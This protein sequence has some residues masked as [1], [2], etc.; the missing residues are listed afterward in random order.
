MQQVQG[1]VEQLVAGAHAE[2]DL[3]VGV[4]QLQHR[5]AGRVHELV[6]RLALK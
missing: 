6:A 3:A 5:V 2:Q 4:V 1:D